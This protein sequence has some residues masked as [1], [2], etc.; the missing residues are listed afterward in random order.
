MRYVLLKRS[1]FD[2]LVCLSRGPHS[3]KP[4]AYSII[5]PSIGIPNP[6]DIQYSGCEP[7][8]GV[9][10]LT[11][12]HYLYCAIIIIIDSHDTVVITEWSWLLLMAWR[13][14]GARIS[15][16][17]MMRYTGRCISGTLRHNGSG[18]YIGRGSPTNGTMHIMDQYYSPKAQLPTEEMTSHTRNPESNRVTGFPPHLI[19]SSLPADYSVLPG[20]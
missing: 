17:A 16:T 12:T 5:S 14:F 19:D 15:A 2:Y 6:R 20:Q 13:L 1:S 8:N 3:A 7:S 4:L 10:L 9:C 18:I 11:V